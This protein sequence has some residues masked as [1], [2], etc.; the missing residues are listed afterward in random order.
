MK[1]FK[2]FLQKQINEDGPV[3]VNNVGGGS[4][5][6][7]GVGPDGA[8]PGTKGIMNKIVRR[9]RNVATKLPS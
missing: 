6:G 1:T 8:P 2:S 4:I 7:V 3:A 5:P 9:K